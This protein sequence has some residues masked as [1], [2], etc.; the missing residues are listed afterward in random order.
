VREVAGRNREASASQHAGPVPDNCVRLSERFGYCL[1]TTSQ[2][3]NALRAH[4][5]GELDVEGFWQT[6]FDTSGV[7]PLPELDVEA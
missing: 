6:I 2:V 7:C 3:F 5:R 1:V 4:Q